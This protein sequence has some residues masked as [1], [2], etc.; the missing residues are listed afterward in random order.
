MTIQE[1]FE[2]KYYRKDERTGI[3]Y[4]KDGSIQVH[5]CGTQ[6]D[7]IKEDIQQIIQEVEALV[8]K[9]TIKEILNYG[10]SSGCVYEDEIAKYAQSKGITL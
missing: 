5:V 2:N 8:R 1:L 9:E 4:S 3:I 7:L 10:I 6:L